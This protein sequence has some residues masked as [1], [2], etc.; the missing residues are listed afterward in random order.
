MSAMEV[1]ALYCNLYKKIIISNIDTINEYKTIFQRH[2]II[3][4]ILEDIMDKLN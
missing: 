2:D 4:L 1:M 3:D